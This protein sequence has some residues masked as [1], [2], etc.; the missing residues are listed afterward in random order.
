[1]MNRVTI[2]LTEK[3]AGMNP[4]TRP[5]LTVGASFTVAVPTAGDIP[6]RWIDVASCMTE[7]TFCSSGV[8]CGKGGNGR[9]RPSDFGTFS[10]PA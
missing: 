10:D 7:D 8:V 9:R 1:M 6:S 3:E 4:W 2:L 5:A